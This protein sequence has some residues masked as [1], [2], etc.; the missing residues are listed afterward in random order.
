MCFRFQKFAE[1]LIK[2]AKQHEIQNELLDVSRYDP[3]DNLLSDVS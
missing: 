1:K 2:E 3:E